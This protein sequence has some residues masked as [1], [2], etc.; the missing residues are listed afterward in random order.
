LGITPSESRKSE[1]LIGSLGGVSLLADEKEAVK[2]LGFS[3]GGISQKMSQIFGR[4]I[5][6]V[7]SY[8]AVELG[9]AR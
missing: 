5:I 8:C 2:Q 4:R 7:K 1:H 6:R 9:H 3:K